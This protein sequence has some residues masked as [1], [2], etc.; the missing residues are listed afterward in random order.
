MSGFYQSIVALIL[1]AGLPLLSW[2]VS[3]PRRDASAPL[4]L[5]GTMLFALA[6]AVYLFP[7][8]VPEFLKTALIRAPLY[9]ALA[10][11]NEFFRKSLDP[12]RGPER[13]AWIIALLAV[14]GT[15]FLE[16]YFGVRGVVAH[17]AFLMFTQLR[18]LQGV[19][20]L[21]RR[22]RSRG[23]VSIG[24]AILL[25]FLANGF[26]VVAAG[27]DGS[28]IQP[29]LQSTAGLSIY[30]ANIVWV[31]LFSIGYW[32]YS[33]DVS[34]AAEVA[35]VAARTAETERRKAAEASAERLAEVVRQRDRL[36]MIGSRFETLNNVGV[37]NAAVIHELS[38]PLQRILINSDYLSTDID[39]PKSVMRETLGEISRDAQATSEIVHAVRALLIDDRTPHSLV[40]AS[41]VFEV[42]KPIIESQVRS[43]GVSL[44][45][46]IGELDEA[47]GVLVNPILLNRVILNI[48]SNSLSALRKVSGESTDFRPQVFITVMARVL[49]GS[50]VLEI[51][52]SDNGLGFPPDF[53]LSLQTIG[54]DSTN[55]GMG[56]GLVIS[57]QMLA[58]WR[59][60]L[61]IRSGDSGTEVTIR[62]PLLNDSSV[63]APQV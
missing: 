55:G 19:I 30:L 21:Q 4:F 31:M 27:Y 61:S 13:W 46:D 53:D 59:G 63:G 44:S 17:H 22:D 41:R 58:A 48:F 24:A 8:A 47:E 7:P 28:P 34:R 39:L 12:A 2:A 56:L 16:H 1:I 38:Q 33:V 11:I 50:R 54:G 20:L 40:Q 3:G 45:I 25:V 14:P 6:A 60:T 29:N 57:R 36:I 26:Q 10:L 35:S 18:L 43:E 51:G 52:I 37:F 5:W 15:I 62:L 23:L 42:V 49:S 32:A 9:A